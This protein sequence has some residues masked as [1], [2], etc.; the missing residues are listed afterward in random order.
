M[1]QPTVWLIGDNAWEAWLTHRAFGETSRAHVQWVVCDG[2]DALASLFR[3]GSDADPHAPCP[4][5]IVLDFHNPRVR[6]YALVQRLKQDQRLKLV[7]II[8]LTSSRR[9]EDIRQAYQA[10]VNAYMLKP[11]AYARLTEALG[12]LGAFWLERVELPPKA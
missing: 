7:P 8:V 4:D 2:E 6:G 10:G 12:H 3:E 1:H 5:V 9:P 11:T